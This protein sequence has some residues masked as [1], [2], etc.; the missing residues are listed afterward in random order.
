MASSLTSA[1][2]IGALPS[3]SSSGP[4]SLHGSPTL[5]PKSPA[6]S[7]PP[8]PSKEE[9][10][11]DAVADDSAAA[12]AAVVVA[13]SPKSEDAAAAAALTSSQTTPTPEA[14][15]KSESATTTATTTTAVTAFAALNEVKATPESAAVDFDGEVEA[16]E[17]KGAEMPA[18]AEM[19]S[20]AGRA[21]GEAQPEGEEEEEEE[22]EEHLEGL[23]D[24]EVMCI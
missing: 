4:S 11:G 5:A 23:A 16:A 2:P 22:E 20:V 12:A 17:M 21:E 10:E 9:A 18:D 13:S 7:S 6:T 1:P 19:K 24:D 14:S 8:P 15:V 3:A